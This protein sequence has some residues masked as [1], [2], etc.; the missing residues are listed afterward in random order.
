MAKYEVTYACGHTRTVNLFGKSADRERK[1]QWLATINCPDCEKAAEQ[2]EAEAIEARL[3]LS[4]LTGSPKQIAWA[5]EIRKEAIRVIERQLEL[6]KADDRKADM[7]FLPDIL[8]AICAHEE[9]AWWIEN[10][11]DL[12]HIRNICSLGE[13]K[14]LC[15]ENADR[16]RAAREE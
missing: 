3:Q 9:A 16:Y 7:L 11:D 2:Q 14:Q 13:I 8:R 1:L 12:Q 15:K 10:R 4:E 6:A 5:R